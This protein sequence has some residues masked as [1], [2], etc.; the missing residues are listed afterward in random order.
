M[1]R[2]GKT[3]QKMAGLEKEIKIG[4]IGGTGKTGQWFKRYFESYGYE[5]FIAG[6]KTDL[7]IEECAKQCD[8]V[9]VSVPISATI[10]MI[11]R[12]APLVKEDALLMDFTSIKTGPVKAMLEHSKCE[13]IG[14][15]PMFGPSVES[16]TN[17][18]IVL[19][20]GR[21]D[22][23]L[24]WAKEIFTKGGAKVKISTPQKH[25]EM[26][27]VI[28]GVI[29]FSSI[30]ISHVLKK[31]GIDVLESQ[32]YSS[33][34]Y[35]LRMDMVGRILSQDPNLYADIEL[36]N[37]EISKALK[38]YMDTS[39]ELFDIIINKNKEA[40]IKYFQEGA[41]YLGDF[42]KEADEYSDYIIKKLVEKKKSKGEVLQ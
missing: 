7:S 25:D 10:E 41:D 3:G 34:V 39:N 40:F 21:G 19:C 26:T 31:L 9:I 13:V 6:R 20:P 15:H 28:Q 12:V 37:P 16:L 33:P 42:K 22:K 11:K 4:I 38:A 1:G 29:H 27:S 35:K 14:V 2:N 24:P 30:T 18:T 17:Q 5:V 32:D 8:A 23:W 36:E